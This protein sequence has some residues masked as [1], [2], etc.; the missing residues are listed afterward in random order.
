MSC[1]PTR[2]RSTRRA[3]RPWSTLWPRLSSL[4]TCPLA[5]LKPLAN[6]LDLVPARLAAEID[7]RDLQVLH[8]TWRDLEPLADLCCGEQ[9]IQRELARFGEERLVRTV[10]QD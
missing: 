9:R 7:P 10:F 4:S 3:P 8:L 2:A 5:S 6:V 1:A